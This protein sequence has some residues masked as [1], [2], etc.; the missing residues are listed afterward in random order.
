MTESARIELA[1]LI[2]NKASE[3]A[4]LIDPKYSEEC[5]DSTLTNRRPETDNERMIWLLHWV[6]LSVNNSGLCDPVPEAE[7]I[8][9][10]FNSQRFHL[11]STDY[12]IWSLARSIRNR[13]R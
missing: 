4:E 8:V 6:A 10:A 7:A 5:S 12:P 9:N 3:L 11:S 1:N 2:V 13:D